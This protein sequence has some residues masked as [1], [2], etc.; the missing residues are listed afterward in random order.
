MVKPEMKIGITETTRASTLRS[1][2]IMAT[3]GAMKAIPSF[4]ESDIMKGRLRTA[5]SGFN[6]EQC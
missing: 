1:S 6:L 4:T 5:V 3:T 2:T